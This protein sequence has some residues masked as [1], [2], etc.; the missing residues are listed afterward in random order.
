MLTGILITASILA[1]GFVAGF[2]VGV[3]L[4]AKYY[5][6]R[7]TDLQTKLSIAHSELIRLKSEGFQQYLS[8]ILQKLKTK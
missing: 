1:V 6:K 2:I 5:V 8:S 7:V 3:R 4:T